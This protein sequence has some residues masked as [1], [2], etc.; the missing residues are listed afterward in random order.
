M[1]H[2]RR[3]INHVKDAGAGWFFITTSAVSV[4]KGKW[5]G[6]QTWSKHP[7]NCLIGQVKEY[8]EISESGD[9]RMIAVVFYPDGLHNF[10]SVPVNKLTGLIID[11]KDVFGKGIGI[12]SK[13]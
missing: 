12:V 8:G 11:S 6:K 4:G 7:V 5:L 10:T 13:S 1:V 2:A 3:L 9:E